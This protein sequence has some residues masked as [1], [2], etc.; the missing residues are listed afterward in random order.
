MPETFVV[1]VT[2]WNGCGG[3]IG[4]FVPVKFDVVGTAPLHVVGTAGAGGS[5]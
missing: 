1:N 4:P 3:V 5:C 2:P